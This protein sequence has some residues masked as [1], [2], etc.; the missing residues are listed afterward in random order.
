MSRQSDGPGVPEWLRKAAHAEGFG[1]ALAPFNPILGRRAPVGAD[2]RAA[3]VLILF[4]GSE[5]ADPLGR[6]GLPHDADVLLTQRAATLRQ[7]SGQV[8]FPGGG[9]D[10]EDDGPVATALREAVEETGLDPAGVQPLAAL[11][12]IY[13][14][15]SG[16]DVTPIV[17][18]WRAPSP[19]G[20]VDHGE[21]ARVARVSVHELL[22]QRNRFQVRTPEGYQGPAF[23]VDGMLV[24]GFTAGV[25][26]GVFAASGW[27]IPWDFH[28]VRGLAESQEA[29]EQQAQRD[30]EAAESGGKP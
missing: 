19:V 20:V 24:W 1:Q 11:P 6:G 15:P 5:A 3:S 18:Y 27:E 25:L 12:Q 30:A 23:G 10:P 16:F 8:A 2:V 21:A 29:A 26:A 7:H 13:V 14:P 22:D 4:G 17:A 9:A 28:D